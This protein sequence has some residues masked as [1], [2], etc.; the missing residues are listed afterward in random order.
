MNWTTGIS[1]AG[2]SGMVRLRRRR[3][4]AWEKASAGSGLHNRSEATRSAA[5]SPPIVFRDDRCPELKQ[6]PL[7]RWHGMRLSAPFVAQILGQVLPQSGPDVASARAAYGHAVAWRATGI[8]LD[9][10]V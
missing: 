1:S 10:D 2:G 6:K 3:S 4:S 8:R 9:R 5:N 7:L